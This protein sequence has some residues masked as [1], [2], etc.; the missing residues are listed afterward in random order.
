[1]QA[2]ITNSRHL[3]GVT[4][5]SSRLKHEGDS[6][7]LASPHRIQV[8]IQVLVWGSIDV[9]MKRAELAAA[10][11][12]K[13]RAQ[14]LKYFTVSARHRLRQACQNAIQVWLLASAA[15]LCVCVSVCVR[16]RTRVVLNIVSSGGGC[17]GRRSK[18]AANIVR[19]AGT[20]LVKAKETVRFERCLKCPCH[21]VVLE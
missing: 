4:Q 20:S 16:A 21:N 6:S 13:N 11:T 3:A 9:M 8:R 17:A 2:P 12:Q 19:T 15:L 5:T 1:M 10:E 18:E 7:H 14:G